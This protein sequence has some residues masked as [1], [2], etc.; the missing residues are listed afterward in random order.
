MSRAASGGGGHGGGTGRRID[1]RPGSIHQPL[2]QR[3]AAGHEPAGTA[4][5]LA[6]RADAD[7]ARGL[8]RPGARP[9]PGRWSPNTPV[10][11]ASSTSSIAPC[12]SGH[13]GQF[14]QRG[15]IAVHAEQAVGH[16]QPAAILAAPRPAS[17]PT[18]AS[19]R[20]DRRGR[21][22]GTAGSRPRGWRGSWRRRRRRRRVRPGRRSSPR[23]AAKPEGNS[24]G[25]LGGLRTRPAAASSRRWAR[26]GR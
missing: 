5:R 16:D 11:W 15:Q 23:L 7:A 25:R 24:S 12:R 20:G 2:D 13:V 17:G 19:R 1:V 8:R 21:R 4:Q 18:A 3:P 6:E 22:P 9:R 26:R 14:D 10:A